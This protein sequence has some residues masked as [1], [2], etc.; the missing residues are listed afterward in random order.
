MIKI[1]DYKTMSD[2][3]IFAREVTATG[4]EDIVADIISEVR[5]KGDAALYAYTE[6]FDKA[7]LAFSTGQFSSINRLKLII[8]LY[9]VNNSSLNNRILF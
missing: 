5:K 2:S 3:D 7:K 6:K 1:Y 9:S 8:S 4:V